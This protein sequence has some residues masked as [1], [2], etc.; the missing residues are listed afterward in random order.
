MRR[1]MFVSF[2]YKKGSTKNILKDMDNVRDMAKFVLWNNK[3]SLA[4]LTFKRKKDIALK[5]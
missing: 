5:I 4:I 3:F 2:N 1:Q